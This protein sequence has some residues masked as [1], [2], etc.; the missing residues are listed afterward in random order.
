VVEVQHGALQR[1]ARVRHTV[2]ALMADVTAGARQAVRAAKTESRA[3][4]VAVT[5][6]A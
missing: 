2:P 1:L 6:R 3:R 4:F 5:D